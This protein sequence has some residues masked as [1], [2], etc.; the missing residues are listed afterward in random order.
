MFIERFFVLKKNRLML[1]FVR[2]KEN[3]LEEWELEVIL[4]Y[5][6]VY[7]LVDCFCIKNKNC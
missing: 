7:I 3:R 2:G 5:L 4:K 6:L 1:V